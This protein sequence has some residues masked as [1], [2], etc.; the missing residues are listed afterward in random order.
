MVVVLFRWL[1]RLFPAEFREQFAEEIGEYLTLRH[2]DEQPAGRWST[3]RLW[4]HMAADLIVAAAKL[5]ASAATTARSALWM[6]AAIGGLSISVASLSVVL[7]VFESLV[8]TPLLTLAK[9]ATDIDVV[10]RL[11]GIVAAL[12]ALTGVYASIRPGPHKRRQSASHPD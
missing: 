12:V 7:V 9:H 5:R 6:A 2:L 8:R 4:A 1:L 10:P 11:G 3:A